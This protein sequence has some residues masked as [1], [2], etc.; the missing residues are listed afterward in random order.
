[1]EGLDNW[2]KPFNVDNQMF[3]KIYIDVCNKLNVHKNKIHILKGTTNE[4][5]NEI[6]D[7]TMDII[8]VD[9]DHTG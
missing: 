7:N 3:D 4:V 2:N 9:G 6:S 5:I 8:Y 1:M